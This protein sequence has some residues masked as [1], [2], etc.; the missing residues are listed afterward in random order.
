[1]Y[2]NSYYIARRLN[3]LQNFPKRQR[4]LLKI[5]RLLWPDG[6]SIKG[7]VLKCTLYSILMIGEKSLS[8]T[9]ILR[10]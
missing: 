1:M 10:P 4:P 3:T 2:L 9:C 5:Y 6:L 7:S 8:S